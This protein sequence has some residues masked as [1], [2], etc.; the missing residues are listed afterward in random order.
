MDIKRLGPMEKNR[1]EEWT[2]SDWKV[3]ENKYWTDWEKKTPWKEYL[4][5]IKMTKW[6]KW[7]ERLKRERK[8][9]IELTEKIEN[10]YIIQ[11]HMDWEKWKMIK[12]QCM[13]EKS[14]NLYFDQ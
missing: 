7:K 10:M 6:L 11:N 5:I 4:Y 3:K 12:S 8:H 14:R 13:T 9:W 2:K 1:L